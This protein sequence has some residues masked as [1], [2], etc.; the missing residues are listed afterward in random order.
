MSNAVINISSDGNNTVVAGISGQTIT[1]F[2][3]FFQCGASTTL[4]F[5]SGSSTNL[6]G[7]MAFTA[8][9]GMNIFFGDSTPIFT[10]NEGDALVINVSGLLPQVG[11]SVFYSQG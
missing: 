3:I 4:T 1:V 5:K 8:G 11:G 6:T 9:G 7:P 2:A 10:L